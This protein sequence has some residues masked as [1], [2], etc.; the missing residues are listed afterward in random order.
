MIELMT[1]DDWSHVKYFSPAER[2]GDPYRIE[3]DLV[4]LVDRLRG[5]FG[6]PFVIHC[7]LD[8]YGHV[9][10]T[11]HWVPVKDENGKVLYY[12]SDAVDF[13]VEN[14]PFRDAVD[15][16]TELIGPA[17][18]LNVWRVV[19]LGI[20]PHWANPGFH[21]DTHGGYSRWGAVTQGGKQ[22]YVSW[23]EAYRRIR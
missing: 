14:M 4:F 18:N 20:Y 2:W 11:R 22:V 12:Y 13:H 15:L 9:A 16:M 1:K 3:K 21:L 8:E 6:R 7:G 5:L 23:E 10:N 19:G 17:P